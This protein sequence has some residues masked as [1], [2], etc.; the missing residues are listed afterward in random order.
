[1]SFTNQQI[2]EFAVLGSVFGFVLAVWLIGVLLW[3]MFHSSRA[4]QVHQR[5]GLGATQ[6]TDARVLTLWKDGEEASTTVLTSRRATFMAWVDRLRQEAGIQTPAQSLVL[7]VLGIGLLVFASVTALSSLA[8][9]L[10]VVI[11]VVFL[12]WLYFQTRITRRLIRFEAQ[13]VDALE[14]TARSLKAGHTLLGAFRLVAEE[15]PAPVSTVFSEIC[16]LQSLGLS[17]EDALERTAKNSGSAD[18]HLFATS[19]AIQLRSGGNLAEMMNR[20]AYV[21]RDRMRLKR[22]VRVLTAQTQ[23]SKRVLMV[24]PFVMFLV[25][26]LL[27]PK[28]MS[29]LYTTK[30]GHYLMMLALTGILLGFWVMNRLSVLHY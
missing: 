23:M 25:L 9:A 24:L 20:L 2:L 28:Y 1:M 12:V 5:L 3:T 27:N 15:L 11:A 10:A 21:I 29:I 14:L 17:L 22:R 7:G 19:V 26:N 16:Q 6:P 18:M 8:V 4:R 13:L 30:I